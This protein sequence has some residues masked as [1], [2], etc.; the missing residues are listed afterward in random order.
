MV[1]LCWVRPVTITV[2]YIAVH[3]TEQ[4]SLKDLHVLGVI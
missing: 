4:I 1:F 3:I 2:Q